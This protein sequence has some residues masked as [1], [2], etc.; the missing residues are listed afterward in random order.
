M[1]FELQNLLFGGSNKL[2]QCYY[3]S[4][5]LSVVVINAFVESI[6]DLHSREKDN[7]I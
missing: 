7:V 4:L 5:Q 1:F 3:L 2:N 6:Y